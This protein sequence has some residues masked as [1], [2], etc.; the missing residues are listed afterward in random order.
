V[1]F[2]KDVRLFKEHLEAVEKVVEKAKSQGPEI[3]TRN[4]DLSSLKRIVGD[5]QVT[6]EQCQTLI[7]RNPQL[8]RDQFGFV[9]NV[10]WTLGVQEQVRYL[11][12]S[13]A[14]HCSK[15]RLDSQSTMYL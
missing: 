11:H 2:G 15:V 7:S 6:L 10:Q 8:A 12:N 4:W 13:I 3:H 14:F 1:A 9:Q 5:F